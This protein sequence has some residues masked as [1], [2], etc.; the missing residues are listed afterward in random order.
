MRAEG[1]GQM[2]LERIL[3]A[4][5]VAVVGAS[6]NPTKRGYQAIRTLLEEGY[7]GRIYP[8]NPKESEILGLK[9]YPKV[10]E[11]PGDVDLAL[12]TTPARTVP[13][14]LADCGRK[15]VKGAVIIAGG[16]RETGEEGRR[17]EQEV[18]AAARANAIRLIGPNT[19][20]MMNLVTNMNLV[21]MREV[22]RGEVALLSQSGNMALTLI[23]EAK[24]TT[25][26]GFSYYVGVGNEADIR[27][28]EYL[29][30][31]RDDPHTSAV[32]MYVEGMKDGRAF[33]AEAS[34]T[35]RRKPVVMLKS[36]RSA[37]GRRSAGSHTG[38]LAGSW[39]VTRAALAETGVVV[40]T[41]SDELVPVTETLCYQPPMARPRLA[42]LADGGGHATIASDLLTDM[43]ISV[44]PLAEQTQQRLKELLPFTA[45]VVNPVDVAGGT[46]ADPMVFAECA[47]A[48]FADPNVDGVLMVGLFGGYGIRFDPSLAEAEVA[49][50]RR[51]CD[52][53]RASGK[54]LVVHSLFAPM[55]PEALKLMRQARVPVYSSLDIACAC[56]GALARYGA[57]LADPPPLRDYTLDPERASTARGRA[58]VE[59]GL[60]AGHGWLMEPEVMELLRAHGVEVPRGILATSP[61][62][63]A[64]AYRELGVGKVVMKV[65]SP[66]VMHKSDAGGVVLGVDSEQKAAQAY[67]Q[68]V[69][70]VA[71]R[72]PGAEVQGVFVVPQAEGY[73]VEVIVG[74]KVDEQFGPVIMVGMG[75]VLVEIM[76]DVAFGVVPVEEAKAAQLIRSLK[77]YKLLRG[78]RGR[79]AVDE[80]ALARVVAGCSRIMEAYPQIVEMDLNPVLVMPQGVAVLDGRVVLGQRD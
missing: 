32:L 1:E 52:I 68:I 74:G 23:T 57:Y 21:G 40:L 7:Q 31:F 55:G 42:I 16:F 61:E 34:A 35:T 56:V 38:A 70:S 22:P 30:F 6:R 45:S 14:I 9:C 47:E 12:I 50:A 4:G 78:A 19:S 24:L 73:G 66:Q 48:I 60:K 76:Q 67:T 17:L 53:A 69:Q 2:E 51:I 13:A 36:G 46:D 29:R 71:R 63:A 33:L 72:V 65:V 37:T 39:E 41:H 15:G 25:N 8:V 44:P 28:H 79:P 18:V 3:K 54:P 62:E 59:Q 26:L 64:A 11:I 77:G 43:G 75:G 80:G 5:S 49:A 20:G 10:S 58:I 27:F